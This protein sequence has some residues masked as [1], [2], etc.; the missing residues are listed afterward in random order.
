MP[1]PRNKTRLVVLTIG[2]LAALAIGAAGV[3]KF[4]PSTPWQRFFVN[5]GYPAW[6]ALVVGAA[7]VSGAILAL[8]PRLAFYGAIL[9]GVIMF[10]ASATLALHRGVPPGWAPT[11]PV[12]YLAV[13]ASFAAVRW[14]DRARLSAHA[15]RPAEVP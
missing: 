1:P 9:L 7:E 15:I 4:I 11:T 2:A 3:A 14:R 12:V 8:I 5:W 10:G 6:F 13:L